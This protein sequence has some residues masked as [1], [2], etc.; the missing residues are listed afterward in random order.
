V[1]REFF[2]RLYLVPSEEMEFERALF[3]VYER[4]L[5]GF[6]PNNGQQTIKSCE[7]IEY[8]VSAV[9]LLFLGILI[10]LHLIFV[11]NPGCL[12]EKLNAYA[13]AHNASSF[14]FTTDQIIQITLTQQEHFFFD[15]SDYDRRNLN[16]LYNITSNATNS[17]EPL[18]ITPDYEFATSWALL[19]LSREIRRNHNFELVNLT[20]GSEC[21]G[22]PLEQNLLSFGGLDVVMMNNLM[23][24]LPRGGV[25]S[26]LTGR[27]R[28]YSWSNTAMKRP[29]SVVDWLS[30]KS[31]ILTTSLLSYFILSTTNALFVRIIVSSGV[32]LLLPFFLI[33][34][35]PSFLSSFPLPSSPV[36]R[37]AAFIF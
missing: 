14:N 5:E 16:Q 13:I 28:D 22:T 17:T 20:Y 36:F 4:C 34:Q 3:V 33:L 8:L 1:W 23:A 27:P 35:V 25:L 10:F 7:L 30:V 18:W 37:C 31:S 11:G 12:P 19:G 26:A 9:T 21:F 6:V 15:Q 32:V 24:T 29:Q 2:W